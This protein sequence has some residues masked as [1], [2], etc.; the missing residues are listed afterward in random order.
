MG[1]R[2]DVER[3]ERGAWSGERGAGSGERGAWSVERGAGSVERGAWSGGS[4]EG[5]A[6]MGNG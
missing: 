4:V 1:G 3:R 2:A 6:A 5:E